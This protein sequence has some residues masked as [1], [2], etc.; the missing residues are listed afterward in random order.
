MSEMRE[1]S[2]LVKGMKINVVLSIEVGV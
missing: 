2:E 1:T